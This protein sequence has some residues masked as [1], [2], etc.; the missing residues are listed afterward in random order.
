MRS[1]NTILEIFFK[2]WKENIVSG[3]TSTAKLLEYMKVAPEVEKT[4]TPEGNV[5]FTLYYFLT[6]AS[7]LR[8]GFHT[9]P[10]P[11][12]KKETNFIY[13]IS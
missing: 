5:H 10:I 7:Y 12:T 8:K 4:L 1:R 13:F 3:T 2:A 11:H 6:A 9:H